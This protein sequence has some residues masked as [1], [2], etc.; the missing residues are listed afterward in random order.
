VERSGAAQVSQEDED[1]FTFRV[2]QAMLTVENLVPERTC[3]ESWVRGHD[4]RFKHHGEVPHSKKNHAGNHCERK[5]RTEAT[6]AKR[7]ASTGKD[8][9]LEGKLGE[10]KVMGDASRRAA[11]GTTHDE[12]RQG[13]SPVRVDHVESLL[14]V[15]SSGCFALA[16]Q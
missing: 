14:V 9:S 13:N 2:W 8:D 11:A 10:E 1:I 7:A 4:S 6:L 16:L 15:L 12:L 5:H 3:L